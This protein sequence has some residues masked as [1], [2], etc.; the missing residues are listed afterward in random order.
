MRGRRE[1]SPT[2]WRVL[3][4]RFAVANQGAGR[5]GGGPRALSWVR[6]LTTTCLPGSPAPRNAAWSAHAPQSMYKH[7]FALAAS[8]HAP[9]SICAP[10]NHARRLAE[11]VERPHAVQIMLEEELRHAAGRP[12]ARASAPLL[13]PRRSRSRSRSRHRRRSRHRCG[14]A[15]AGSLAPGPGQ[16]SSGP[17]RC[18]AERARRAPAL[19]SRVDPA[20]RIQLR[21]PAGPPGSLHPGQ[22]LLQQLC[23]EQGG[24]A[25]RKAP[26]AAGAGAVQRAA[27]APPAAAGRRAHARAH[28][29][30]AARPAA[31]PGAAAAALARPRRTRGL[32]GGGR[33]AHA[34]RTQRC[35]GAALLP[36]VGGWVGWGGGGRR[37]PPGIAARP[38]T[39]HEACELGLVLLQQAPEAPSRQAPRV[40]HHRPARGPARVSCG[41]AVR[42]G[43]GRRW[44][45][46]ALSPQRL[47][48][49]QVLVRDSEA[50]AGVAY[51]DAAHPL[52]RREGGAGCEVGS[53][54]ARARVAAEQRARHAPTL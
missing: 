43:A 35:R 14:H 52:R 33:A 32:R 19:T 48:Q 12:R 7:L 31:A 28:L 15:R 20:R 2:A 46:A 27:G 50:D 40:Q 37:G 5:A 42:G 54:C 4:D 6:S 23:A 11:R 8:A 44:A 13:L 36:V 47:R 16:P 21:R 53:G 41:A 3:P 49:G 39:E 45:A 18:L 1:R 9:Q 25:G 17:R 38:P 24:R 10:P 26:S 34:G 22:P 51:Q 29:A 30:P